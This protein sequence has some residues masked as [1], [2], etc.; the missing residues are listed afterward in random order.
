MSFSLQMALPTNHPI[1]KPFPSPR[2]PGKG[3]C[4]HF[5]KKVFMFMGLS[6]RVVNFSKHSH[7]QLDNVCN[8][9]SLEGAL[10]PQVEIPCG[11][12]EASSLSH[13]ACFSTSA[14]VCSPD[15][16]IISRRVD[17]YHNFHIFK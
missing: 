8:S 12:G 3:R 10:R 7:R 4:G 2:V 13:S 9:R 6:S 1:I 17:L 16:V 14:V 5:A 15:L 11:S